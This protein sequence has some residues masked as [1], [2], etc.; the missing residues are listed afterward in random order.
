MSLPRDTLAYH[1]T[2][3]LTVPKSME[4]I[5]CPHIAAAIKPLLDVY[6]VNPETDALWFYQM[7]HG[8]SEVGKKYAAL[9]PLP[10]DVL[11]FVDH[12]YTAGA[13]KALRSFAYLMLITVREARHLPDKGYDMRGALYSVTGCN[14][15]WTYIKA[16]PSEP[17]VAKDWFVMSPP[18]MQVI[19]M[20]KGLVHQ[21]KTGG[22]GN[23][24]GGEAWA[25]ITEC[26]LAFAEG[27]TSA[28][29]MSDTVWTLNHN[30]GAIFNK[31]VIFQMHT[32]TLKKVLDVQRAGM[33]PQMIATYAE[34]QK[35][36]TEDMIVWNNWLRSN[37]PQSAGGKID[38]LRVEALGSVNKYPNEIAKQKMKDPAYLAKVAADNKAAKDNDDAYPKK[39]LADMAAYKA[40]AYKAVEADKINKMYEVTTG[41]WVPKFQPLRLAKAA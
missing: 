18:A 23:G 28:E 1:K 34:A 41:K 25:K 33:I 27:K 6:Q 38:W 3:A 2:R 32:A 8:L 10:A 17:E 9:E 24:Y 4:G 21:F 12:Y 14:T 19:P 31:S 37:F 35:F 5:G 36:T 11:Q 26:A 30:N 13:E 20:L 7:N 39:M 40:A 16:T 22:Y 29:V 15:L